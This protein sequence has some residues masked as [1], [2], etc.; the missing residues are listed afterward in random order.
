MRMNSRL[1]VSW[2]GRCLGIAALSVGALL[3]TGGR[4]WAVASVTARSAAG[5]PARQRETM[6]A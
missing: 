4:A 1:S 3:A 2:V 6:L 5:V